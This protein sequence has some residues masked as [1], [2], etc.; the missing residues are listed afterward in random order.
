MDPRENANIQRLVAQAHA[1]K[2]PASTMQPTD[3][4]M[5]AL[6]TRMFSFRCLGMPDGTYVRFTPVIPTPDGG[7]VPIGDYHHDYVLDEGSSFGLSMML[8]AT[9]SPE[10]RE[11]LLQV[12]AAI[13]PPEEVHPSDV[14]GP[15]D[16]PS[17]VAA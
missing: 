2:Q 11:E 15:L 3:L 6:V 5:P 7:H 8:A 1:L 14:E 16:P 12:I 13:D 17:D 9:L 10:K 4:P